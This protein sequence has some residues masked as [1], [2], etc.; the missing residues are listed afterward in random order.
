[1]G[2]FLLIATF[3]MSYVDKA[4][5]YEDAVATAKIKE[6]KFD[7]RLKAS[8]EKLTLV[9]TVLDA[10]FTKSDE[11][12]K[13]NKELLIYLR[14][15]GISIPQ[16]FIFDENREV[17]SSEER[18]RREVREKIQESSKRNSTANSTADK[19]T[20]NDNGSGNGNSKGK[21]KGNGKDKPSKD[22]SNNGK[23]NGKDK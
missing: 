7:E 8:D 10:V 9:L 18:V 6:D 16:R 12:V 1:M 2:F 14:S 11:Q 4:Q 13:L 5:A 17:E 23:G 20:G 22:K 3:F 21:D 15:R 19:S